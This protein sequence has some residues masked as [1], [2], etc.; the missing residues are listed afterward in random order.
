MF[1]VIRWGYYASPNIITEMTHDSWALPVDGAF[2]D[3]TGKVPSTE[4]A[5]YWWAWSPT[6]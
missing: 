5:A 3:F 6:N 2:F 4:G 1:F